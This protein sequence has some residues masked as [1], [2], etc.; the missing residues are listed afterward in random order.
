MANN[1]DGRIA[2]SSRVPGSRESAIE[3]H[4]SE[5][6]RSGWACWYSAL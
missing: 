6:G 4:S 5:N 2:T 1:L 3:G